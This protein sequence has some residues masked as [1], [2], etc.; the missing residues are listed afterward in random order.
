[1]TP[2]RYGL[3]S[4]PT[5]YLFQNDQPVDGFQGPQPEEAIRVLLD[6]VLLR[7]EVLKVQQAVELMQEGKHA[8]ALP[9]LGDAWQLSGQNSEIAL[10]LA[11]V[12]IALN[13]S[14]DA[15]AV[16]KTV[17]LLWICRTRAPPLPGARF[18]D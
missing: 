16:P 7:E 17:P 1:M 9:L 18:P 2:S 5:V 4:M 11:E 6:N 10:L 12:E 13:R 14:E 3:R 8:E 15:E